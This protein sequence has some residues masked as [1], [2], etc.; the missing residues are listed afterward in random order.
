MGH[1][2]HTDMF[3]PTELQR[4]IDFAQLENYKIPFKRSKWGEKLPFLMVNVRF[5]VKIIDFRGEK[6]GN[7]HMDDYKH[8]GMFSRTEYHPKIDSTPL[9]NWK[10]PCK[11][12][13]SGEIFL[14][15]GKIRFSR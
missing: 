8:I 15:N 12:S 11:R 5:H 4:E 1:C 10:G 13:K 14:I 2:R 3:S 7:H 9:G 6:I